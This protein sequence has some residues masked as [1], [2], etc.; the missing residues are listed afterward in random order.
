M[1][2]HPSLPDAQPA[3]DEAS[4][5]ADESPPSGPATIDE[6]MV[7]AL[8]RDLDN[9]TRA[10]NGMSSFIPVCAYLLARATHAPDLVWTA[11]SIAID[12]APRRLGESTLSDGIW[13]G[14][15]M[16]SNSPNE[17]WTWAQGGRYNTFA[18]RGAQIDR[19][20]NVNNTVIGSLDEPRV[21]LPG[22][23][24]MPD[25]SCLMPIIYLWSTTHDRRTFVERLDFRSGLGWGDGGDHRA[26]LGLPGGPRL[27]VTN[28]CVFDFHPVS[29]S[30]RLASV[31]PGVSVDDVRDA[32][33]FD[34]EAPDAVPTTPLPTSE[35]L[36]ILRQEVD[37]TSMRL[38]EFA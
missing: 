23:A 12:A 31:H 29:R 32:T 30:M 14:A 28:L 20:G 21:R 33:G 19:F 35:E 27:C 22:S 18:F 5:G 17:F 10:F 9:D 25:L 24:G 15:T 11:S 4:L 1:N 37:P 34:V 26:R 7:V 2:D 16:L 13:D 36:R 8:A 38:R 3:G 6:V